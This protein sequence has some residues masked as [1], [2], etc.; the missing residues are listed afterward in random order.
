MRLIIWM[1]A[2]IVML[3]CNN[4]D[5]PKLIKNNDLMAIK[6]TIS[7]RLY[8]DIDST[9]D[10]GFSY[11]ELAV[12]F[13]R[14]DIVKYFIE[15]RANVNF[16]DRYGTTPLKI[17]VMRN[18]NEIVKYL[19][20]NNANLNNN[21]RNFEPVIFTAITANNVEMLKLLIAN[22]CD[23]NITMKYKYINK[24]ITPIQYCCMFQNNK[25]IL[26]LLIKNGAN[27]N[28]IDKEGNTLLHY[29]SSN[30]KGD[31]WELIEV[32]INN[33]LDSNLRNINGMTALMI[34][35]RRNRSGNKMKT[36]SLLKKY[37]K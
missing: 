19:I 23:V 11:L 26:K 29:A 25:D 4:D 8:V 3:S 16:I 27:V 1:F 20:M 18:K 32:L 5:I 9:D 22:R 6:T 28:S 7:H 36:I 37:E 35:E 15:K 17:A 2:F 34:A 13:G 24:E 14:Y 30:S 12:I 33:N 10:S 21:K 31:A